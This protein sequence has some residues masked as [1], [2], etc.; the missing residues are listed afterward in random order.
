MGQVV[1]GCER[2]LWTL[3]LDEAGGRQ[4]QNGG[5]VRAECLEHGRQQ[6]VR[7]QQRD[8]LADGGGEN[9]GGEQE[10]AEDEEELQEQMKGAE[11]GAEIRQCY[12]RALGQ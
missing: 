1:P 2:I 5:Y 7:A 3:H 11:R 9:G 4:H 12:A 8:V 6:V 10:E